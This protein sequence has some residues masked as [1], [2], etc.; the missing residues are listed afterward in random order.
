MGESPRVRAD[1][2]DQTADFMLYW[3]KLN[4]RSAHQS[5]PNEEVSSLCDGKLPIPFRHRH[6]DKHRTNQMRSNLKIPMFI[7]QHANST[8]D[9]QLKLIECGGTTI[10]V[11]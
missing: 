4:L 11:S 1:D 5:S 8:D 7:L 6:A 3:Y 10:A 9:F 2:E